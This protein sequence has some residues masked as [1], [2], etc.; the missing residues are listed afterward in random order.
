MGKTSLMPNPLNSAFPR[1]MPKVGLREASP[2]NPGMLF[3]LSSL[4]LLDIEA[5][6]TSV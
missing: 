2:L 3:M 4:C 1:Y 5:I 6:K